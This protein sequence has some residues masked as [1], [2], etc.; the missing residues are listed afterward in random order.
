MV[1]ELERL[2]QE[3]AS[4]R[5]AVNPEY[6]A[7]IPHGLPPILDFV[8]MEQDEL[9][10][11]RLRGIEAALPKDAEGNLLDVHTRYWWTKHGEIHTGYFT[12]MED[13]LTAKSW[14]PCCPGAYHKTR[15]AAEK[16]RQ[17]NG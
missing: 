3:N 15:E 12:M 9:E 16:A 10:L 7:T 5:L 13:S 1:V 2:R 4:L 6:L 14:A 17:S 8:K 11:E